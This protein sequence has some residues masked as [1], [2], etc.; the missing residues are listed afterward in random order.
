MLSMFEIYSPCVLVPLG[1]SSNLCQGKLQVA[2]L[3]RAPHVRPTLSDIDVP[4]C[5]TWL[6]FPAELVRLVVTMR[7]AR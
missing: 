5:P 1:D 6:P 2:R 4:A 7:L 3:A